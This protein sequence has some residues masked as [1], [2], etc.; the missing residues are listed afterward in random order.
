MR[1]LRYVGWI[2]LLAALCSIAATGAGLQGV[3]T[4]VRGNVVEL[5]L[6]SKDGVKKGMVFV[7]KNR[8]GR[9]ARAQVAEVR[10]TRSTARL[11]Q[12]T[13]VVAVGDAIEIERKGAMTVETHPLSPDEEAFPDDP[14]LK[15]P[16]V[17]ISKVMSA[18]PTEELREVVVPPLPTPVN[19]PDEPPGKK[20]EEIPVSQRVAR[21][22]SAIVLVEVT[23]PNALYWTT[24]AVVSQDGYIV[25]CGEYIAF[26][27]TVHVYVLNDKR[28]PAKVVDKRGPLAL[29]KL[30][31]LPPGVTAMDCQPMSPLEPGTR[32]MA[33]G[34]HLPPLMVL[35]GL[36]FK[37][38]TAWGTFG[39]WHAREGKDSVLEAD[40]EPDIGFLGAPVFRMDTG[41]WAGIITSIRT[42]SEDNARQAGVLTLHRT[43]TLLT[44]TD[45]VRE[46]LQANRVRLGA[47][48]EISI[49]PEDDAPKPLSPGDTLN[50]RLLPPNRELPSLFHQRYRLGLGTSYR[51]DIVA[52]ACYRFLGRVPSAV[53]EPLFDRERLFFGSING[54]FYAFD[55]LRGEAETFW[56]N[57]GVAFLYAPA[58]N[59]EVVCATAGAVN[60]SPRARNNFLR[61]L[62]A[63]A[64]RV[65]TANVVV[66]QVREVVPHI[67]DVG[68]LYAWERATGE[69]KWVYRTRF[70]GPPKIV[71]TRVYFAGLGVLGALDIETGQELWTLPND[72][73]KDKDLTWYHLTHVDEQN[74]FVTAIPIELCLEEQYQVCAAGTGSAQWQRL[75]PQT[76]K[77]QSQTKITSLNAASTALSASLVYQPE[78]QTLRSLI[79]AKIITADLNSGKVSEYK[80]ELSH[81][82]KSSTPTGMV[83]GNGMLYLTAEQNLLYAVDAESGADLWQKPFQSRGKMGAPAV[84]KNRIYV[85]SSDGYLYCLDAA[86]GDV[87]WKAKTGGTLLAKPVVLDHTIYCVSD[88]G[89][90]HVVHVPREV[91]YQPVEREPSVQL[92]RSGLEWRR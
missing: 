62:A 12:K 3:V 51:E 85:G 84:V 80:K 5:S 88:E 52:D 33:L 58:A 22:E 76:G 65:I 23:T 31:V 29:L 89:D 54:R 79:G 55:P 86:K 87:I 72:K 20:P 60:L 7:I 59:R 24:G 56:A 10:A 4:A 1:A 21:V 36:S 48:D 16:R 78:D 90:V 49:L 61:Q 44:P 71:G 6:G 47:R 30:A 81:G 2:T 45:V 75:D 64:A 25:T 67:T 13:G 26:S 46:F 37:A 27:S 14:P 17:H 83:Y 77:L 42:R 66:P 74:L 92:K 9:V 15:S 57:E 35:R 32:A 18:P 91:D 34:Y 43:L 40:M 70:L 28:Y 68:L 73:K 41:Q 63:M 38:T 69:V 82:G 8:S 53:S 39:D 19:T 11:M 50:L